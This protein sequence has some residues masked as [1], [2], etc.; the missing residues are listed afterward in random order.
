MID[1]SKWIS[2]HVWQT[3]VYNDIVFCVP[4]LTWCVNAIF[5][6]IFVVTFLICIFKLIESIT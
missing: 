2:N 5:L 1:I 4:D 3:V 6:I